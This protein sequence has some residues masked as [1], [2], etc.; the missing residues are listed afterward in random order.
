MPLN[1]I[2]SQAS[3]QLFK[4]KWLTLSMYDALPNKDFI[5]CWDLSL[6]DWCC[7]Q[8]FICCLPKKVCLVGS[9]C[10]SFIPSIR[11]NHVK[12]ICFGMCKHLHQ[13]SYLGISTEPISQLL[14]AKVCQCLKLSVLKLHSSVK[15]KNSSHWSDF[16]VW[17]L[18]FLL[19]LVIWAICNRFRQ[20]RFTHWINFSLLWFILIF[21]CSF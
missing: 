3:N 16:T 14:L 5:T 19:C 20:M 7:S 6:F 11:K 4:L 15:K 17:S 10:L 13:T 9:L 1:R 18:F 21:L 2:S 12:I 8:L